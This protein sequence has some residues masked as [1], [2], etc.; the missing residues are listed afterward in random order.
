MTFAVGFDFDHTLGLDNGL[1]VT[2]FYRLGAEL[3]HSLSER[4]APW[5]AFIGEVLGRFRA[6]ETSLE[7]AV[8]NFV[9]RLGL[10][11]APEQAARYRDICYALVND[12][13][14][15]IDGAR[16]LIATLDARRIPHAILTN[17]WSPLQALKIARALDYRK[18]ILVSDELGILKPAA[19]AFD[20]LIDTLG[21]G[22]EHIWFVGDNP[23]TDITG[24]R[25]A[26]LRSVWFDW[27]NMS[28]PPG[29]P[30]PDLRIAHLGDLLDA[31][32]GPVNPT[33]NPRG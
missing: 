32:R 29:A 6:G 26:G 30:E 22:R 27:E 31:L 10:T 7:E 9:A 12:L 28:Y 14:T 33:E 21:V 16:E 3:G 4:D 1:E 18:P 23:T 24:A 15:P 20:K 11:P 17:G 5:S 25:N 13:V 19:A 2:A 8:A